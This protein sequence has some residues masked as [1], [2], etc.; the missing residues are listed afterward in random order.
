LVKGGVGEFG[1][2]LVSWMHMNWQSE[3]SML[4]GMVD[5]RLAELL[6]GTQELPRELVEAMRYSCLAPG[7]RIR[8]VL[9][10][11]SCVA[12]GGTK[13][14]AID[15]ACA[16]EMVHAF[17]LIH[18]DL[19][20]IDNDNLRRGRPTCH[21]AFGE[22]AAILAGDALF[23]LAFEV[24]TEMDCTAEVRIKC[25]ELLS[26]CSGI[27]GLVSGEA[28]DILSEGKPV[29][30]PT[31]ELIHVRKTGALIAA[32]CEMGAVL[33]GGDS[34]AQTKLRSY[35]EKIGLAFQ[36]ADDVLNVEGDAEKTGKSVGSDAERGK[37]TYVGLFGLEASKAKAKSL[38][39]DAI[40]LLIDFSENQLL[41][42]LAFFSVDRIV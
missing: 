13:E 19:P 8:P 9:A 20:A 4:A 12:C 35:G 26:K 10:I 11:A 24:L 42:E 3:M 14:T 40:G 29:S 15:A 5:S 22:A 17:S 30:A 1:D 21:V 25:V 27:R 36:I 2:G 7:K 28:I 33:G 37:A 32:A 18:D 31:L 38:A 39:Q 34:G 6:P 23:A 41:S 16:V